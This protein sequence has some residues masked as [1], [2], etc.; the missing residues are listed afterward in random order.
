MVVFLRAAM[1]RC[2]A[3][4][5]IST[6][7]GTIQSSIIGPIGP[8]R[9]GDFGSAWIPVPQLVERSVAAVAGGDIRRCIAQTDSA[10]KRADLV[11]LAREIEEQKPT[12]RQEQKPHLSSKSVLVPT[13]SNVSSQTL[14][15]K[16]IEDGRLS[17][18]FCPFVQLCRKHC[19]GDCSHQLPS[20]S[21]STLLPWGLPFFDV[22]TG[23][24]SPPSSRRRR[25]RWALER[26]VRQWSNILVLL[27][28]WLR[29]NMSCDQAVVRL[30][31]RP[32]SE[33]QM[34]V[35][36]HMFDAVR[37]WCRSDELILLDGG[38]CQ[39]ADF[40]FQRLQG[41]GF[42]TKMDAYAMASSGPD[43]E[44]MGDGNV[45]TPPSPTTELVMGTTTLELT[46]G[47]V[48]LPMVAGHIILQPPTLPQTLADILTEEGA[49]ARADPPP[50]A[51]DTC[52]FLH[53]CGWV[54]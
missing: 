7:S 18:D 44:K 8:F 47:N 10:R 15:L 13:P 16:C 37:E 46:A 22:F 28:N 9:L 12:V 36:Q 41:E 50:S 49:F 11:R 4:H 17:T 2:D 25:A 45:C 26:Q 24:S 23:A 38:L 3:V 21:S 54:A 14:L 52:P 31:C 5:R 48:A 1:A 20:S 51:T 40:L 33:A 30:C 6:L 53:L 34:H 29:L 19:R 42:L 35:G 39:V 32:A 43:G 27:S